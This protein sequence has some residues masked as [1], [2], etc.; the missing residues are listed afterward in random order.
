[1]AKYYKTPENAECPFT[2][3]PIGHDEYHSV[4]ED[5]IRN[6]TIIHKPPFYFSIDTPEECH[7]VKDSYE[8]TKQEFCKIFDSAI[9]AIQVYHTWNK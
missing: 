4:Q 8:I 5:A 9:N 7:I 3:N 2:E 1:M 6:I